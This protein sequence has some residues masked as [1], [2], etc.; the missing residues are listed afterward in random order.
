MRLHLLGL[1][2]PHP[3]CVRAHV[4]LAQPSSCMEE[5]KKE[6]YQLNKEGKDK[7]TESSLQKHPIIV[8]RQEDVLHV[9]SSV[10]F[11]FSVI[12]APVCNFAYSS[13]LFSLPSTAFWRTLEKKTCI[14]SFLFLNRREAREHAAAQYP[15]SHPRVPVHCT[16]ESLKRIIAPTSSPG[17]AASSIH[18]P[19]HFGFSLQLYNRPLSPST[20]IDPLYACVCLLIHDTVST[21]Y[22]FSL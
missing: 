3:S 7:E 10:G 13:A 14:L 12:S 4:D 19:V 11:T 20:S 16:A 1:H 9:T 18:C 17:N 15:L 5:R 21:Q 2:K 8:E 22:M 6:N